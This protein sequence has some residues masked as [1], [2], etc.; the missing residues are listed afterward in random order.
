MPKTIHRPEYEVLRRLVREARTSAGVTQ[1]DLSSALGRSQSFISDIERGVRRLDIIEL[2]DVC[3]LIGTDLVQLV[4]QFE[5]ELQKQDSPRKKP[6]AG[7]RKAGSR[8][9]RD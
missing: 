6:D 1:V 9:R 2:R 7:T 3:R 8:G 4:R 5:A